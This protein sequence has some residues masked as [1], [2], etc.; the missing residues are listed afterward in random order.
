M[1]KHFGRKRILFFMVLVLFLVFIIEKS[2]AQGVMRNSEWIRPSTANDPAVWGIKNGIVFGLW[3]FNIETGA[4]GGGPRGL[5][6]VGYEFKGNID[7]INFIAIEPVVNG[8]IEFSE[9]S[10]S[11]VDNKWGK[12]MWA[13]DSAN[14]GPYYPSAI[15]RGIISHPDSLHLGVEQLTVYV[16]ME[17]FFNG[18][19]PYLKIAIRNDRPE[20]IC[21]EIFNEKNSATMD[22]CALTAT[23]GNYSRL[24]LLSL[25]NRTIDS[26]ELFKNFNGIDFIEKEEYPAK[27]L[28][29]DKNG[30]FIAI[31]STNESFSKL[32]SWP[33]NEKYYSRWNW[34][35]RPFFKVT[36][37]WRKEKEQ[38]D[39]SLHLRVNGRAKYWSGGSLNKNNYIDIP[40]GPAF[41][42]FELRE[43]YYPRQKFYFGITR[44]SPHDLVRGFP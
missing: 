10:P 28:L 38:A 19:H 3:P 43:K 13:S 14:A 12:F 33:Q 44:K 34:R 35:Y 11:R 30:D 26:R 37:Y 6:R 18:A 7:H 20:E 27:Q 22:R 25:K 29:Q 2:G 41:E 31:A 42:N 36:Q 1:Q 23:M 40:G 8:K 15:S 5:I 9:I 17:R 4:K 39:T 16:F 21:F 32:S 24:R